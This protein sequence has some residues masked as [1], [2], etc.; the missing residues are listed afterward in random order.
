[1]KNGLVI[2]SIGSKRWYLNDVL[3]RDDGPAVEFDNG[4]KYWYL[5]GL[6][7][8]DDGPAAERYNGDKSWHI[9]GQLHRVDGA[10]VEMV[11]GYKIWYL[12]GVSV[13]HPTT[14]DSMEAWLEYLNANENESYQ[15]IHD[16]N[17]FIGF[18][19]NPSGKQIRVHQM[20]WVL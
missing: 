1:M 4:D 5:N 8:R 20:R 18:I 7:H 3:H 2:T 6:Q 16:I 14:F 17:G 12:H 9:T 19:D 15:W 10:A 11:N 13:N